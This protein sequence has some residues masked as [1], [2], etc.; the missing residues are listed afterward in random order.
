MKEK[1]ENNNI[2]IS[3]VCFAGATFFALINIIYSTILFLKEGKWYWDWGLPEPGLFFSIDGAK[4]SL[5]HIF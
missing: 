5:S 1:K 4:F 2:N 3:D